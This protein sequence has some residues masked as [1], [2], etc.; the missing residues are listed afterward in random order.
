KLPDDWVD[1]SDMLGFRSVDRSFVFPGE[2]VPILACL[3][4]S[5]QDSEII[6]PFKVA[7][8]MNKNVISGVKDQNGNMSDQE[9]SSGFQ[10]PQFDDL[11]D[12]KNVSK[13]SEDV[14]ASESFLRMENH[15]KQTQT[16]LQRFKD[17]HF[18]VRIAESG[19]QLW[20]KKGSTE[21]SD[22]DDVENNMATAGSETSIS[23]MIDNGSFDAQCS[24]GAARNSVKC[25]SLMNGDI[26]VLL[27][28]NVGV[29]LLKDPVLEVLQ[30]EKHHDRIRVLDCDVRIKEANNPPGELL[31]WLLPLENSH[32]PVNRSLSPPLMNMSHKSS[33]KPSTGSPLF[34][35][36]NLRSYS[37]SS[38]PQN[39]TPSSSPSVSGGSPKP[40]FDLEDWGHF[41]SQKSMKSPRSTSHGVLSFR[42]VPLEPERFSVCCG[43]EG[44]YIP[45]RRWRKQLEIIQPI[46]IRSFVADC[47]TDD[48]L[49]VLIKNVSPAHIP[50]IV[51]YIDAITIIL[52]EASKGGPSLSFPVACIEAGTDHCLPNLALRRGEEHSFILKP[53]TTVI[54][55]SKDYGDRISQFHSKGR[56]KAASVRLPPTAP[57]AVEATIHGSPSD[58]YAVL[59]SCRCNY[60]ESELFF[61]KSID[62]RPR[63]SRDFMLSVATETLK[64]TLVVS[65]KVS[66]LPVQVLTLQASNFTSEDLNLTILAPG[67]FARPPMLSPNSPPLSP[68]S[69]FA[70]ATTQKLSSVPRVIENH[71]RNDTQSQLAVP[72]VHAPTTSLNCTHS[73]LHSRIPLGCVPSQ[74]TAVIKL[75]LLPLTDG[76]IALDTLQIYVKEQGATYIPQHALKIYATSNIATGIV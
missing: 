29:G 66:Q 73:W 76:I 14:S 25:C 27:Q 52:E 65:R 55:R 53:A 39:V 28:V 68:I 2:Q 40:N 9:S 26:V 17:S 71:K 59:I 48:L 35:L 3:S 8:L 21:A 75:E 34:S 18:F 63:I 4:T 64:Q 61:K 41:R 20:S 62:W 33:F 38:V 30:F 7:A 54:N 44:I 19:E 11:V 51:V 58:K 43:L 12:S 70:F 5:K 13:P 1:A 15:K 46:D 67:S 24:G 56:S 72:V 47:N 6:T 32:L 50:D 22:V 60:S 16:L 36:P 31:K 23:A 74:T 42:G 37:M 49:C 10:Q 45:G 69:P 57:T